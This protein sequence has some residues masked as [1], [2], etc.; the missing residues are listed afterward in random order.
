MHRR[1]SQ[2]AI[3][4]S[5]AQPIFHGFDVDAPGWVYSQ[6]IS[7]IIQKHLILA[8]VHAGSE[9]ER[10]RF[11]AI[12]PQ[13][14]RELVQV[15]PA[16]SRGLHP[17]R[18]DW[19]DKGTYSVYNRL[20]RSE[21]APGPITTNSAWVNYAA[22]YI[23]VAGGIPAIPTVS[24]SISAGWKL[25]VRRAT[26][27]LIMIA[28]NGS[29]TIAFSEISDESRSASWKMYFNKQGQVEKATRS[30]LRPQQVRVMQL[31]KDSDLEHPPAPSSLNR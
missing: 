31:S 11:V 21:R 8:F 6:S 5:R 2:T 12:V 20:L 1:F 19:Q 24:D 3:Q 13:D 16:F 23:A 29:A 15:V 17:F 26:T 30:D 25:A 4:I 18:A 10:S 14:R 7:P 28:K 9:R 27:P 22:L